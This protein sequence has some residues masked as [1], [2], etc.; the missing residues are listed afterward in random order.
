MAAAI[1][2]ITAA[3]GIYAGERANKQQNKY[4]KSQQRTANE[5]MGMGRN[6]YNQSQRAFG[7]ALNH[8]QSL[9][10][11]NPLA[12]RE[13]MAPELNNLAGQYRNSYN[14]VRNLF[15]R[16][17]MLAAQNSN[18]PFDLAGKQTNMMYQA[19]NDAAGKLAGMGGQL[20]QLGLSA[21]GQGSAGQMG[22]FSNDLAARNQQY[23]MGSDAG[24]S[25][26]SA[27][28]NWMQNRPDTG[29]LGATPGQAY[30]SFNGNWLGGSQA[31][32][33]W[34]NFGGTSN[35]LL[36]GST[37]SVSGALGSGFYTSGGRG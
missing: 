36:G 17:G 3:Y 14:S 5:A 9:M 31:G 4:L 8:Y 32:Q 11:G 6:Y 15:G 22:M 21:F 19:R 23:Q 37:N 28:Q 29:A 7:P 24:S 10:S 30:G 27:Y 26:F 35:P 12:V 18:M 16:G 34:G 25:L 13:A 20:G 33:S 1:P 2:V